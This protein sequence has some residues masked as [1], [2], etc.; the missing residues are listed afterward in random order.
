MDFGCGYGT[1]TIPAARIVS[2]IVYGLDIEAEMVELTR[3][4]AE[5]A[6]LTNVEVRQRD[7][8]VEG[9]GLPE[10]SVDYVMLF[11]IL[12]A[13]ERTT[14]LR[15]AWRVLAREGKLAIIHWNYDPS[16]PRGPSLDIRP[17]TGRLPIMGGTGRLQTLASWLDRPAPVSLWFRASTRSIAE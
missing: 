2:G 15:E 13:E 10:A 3:R 12:H 7:F 1:F 4:K 8:V 17:Q 5:E 11:N 16:T 6:C 9:S 14:F